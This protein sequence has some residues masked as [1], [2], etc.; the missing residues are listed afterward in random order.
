MSEIDGSGSFLRCVLTPWPCTCFSK[1]SRSSSGAEL[2]ADA[3][4]LRL[5]A[6]AQHDRVMVDRIG[7]EGRVLVLA[8]QRHAEDVG[9]IFGLLVDVG[10][11]VA[12]VGDLAD[13]DHADS[14]CYLLQTL[15]PRQRADDVD[16]GGDVLFCEAH[17]HEPIVKLDGAVEHRRRHADAVGEVTDHVEIVRE[18]RHGALRRR[19]APLP[20]STARGCRTG[21][22][23]RC[24][25]RS[26]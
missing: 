25:W 7:E 10:H 1:A 6:L 22:S 17:R 5:R 12:G 11:L 8:D 3:H 19:E 15:D 16:H 4:A 24:R 14:P 26:P 2:E 13:A 18:R 9:V 21:S 20:P 23:R